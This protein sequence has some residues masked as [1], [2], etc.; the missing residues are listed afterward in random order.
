MTPHVGASDEREKPVVLALTG[1]SVPV[2]QLFADL[3][4]TPNAAK[5][6]GKKKL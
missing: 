4:D 3:G 6:K 1:F 5:L 2:A